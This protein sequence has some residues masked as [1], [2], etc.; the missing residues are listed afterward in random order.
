MARPP[1]RPP[2]QKRK[3]DLPVGEAV[4]GRAVLPRKRD[5]RQGGIFDAPLRAFI[6][7]QLAS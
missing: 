1:R 5:L 4:A 2:P 3:S 7:P 6:R